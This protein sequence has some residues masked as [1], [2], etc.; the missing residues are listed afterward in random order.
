MM[1]SFVKNLE[2]ENKRFI[3]RLFRIDVGSSLKFFIQATDE[4]GINYSYSMEC[5]AGEWK[6]VY[7]TRQNDLI[8]KHEKKLS[9]IIHS[10][11][12]D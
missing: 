4:N 8:A 12:H 10:I 1:E 9:E 7:A 3:L 6:L 2:L 11:Q 5:E